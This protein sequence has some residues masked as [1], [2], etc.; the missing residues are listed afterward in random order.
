MSPIT[1]FLNAIGFCTVLISKHLV[2]WTSSL[3][4]K[5]SL[6]FS[7]LKSLAFLLTFWLIFVFPLSSLNPLHTGAFQGSIPET[8]ILKLFLQQATPCPHLSALF[9]AADHKHCVLFGNNENS[10]VQRSSWWTPPTGSYS[11]NGPLTIY[12]GKFNNWVSSLIS[13]FF[14]SDVQSTTKS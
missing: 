4:W 13:L 2:L 10:H 3:P 12:L 1:I 9:W 11:V 5:S 7:Y 14:L 6:G 8:P